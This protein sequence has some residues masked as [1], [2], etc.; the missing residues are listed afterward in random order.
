VVALVR[1]LISAYACDPFGGSEGANAWFTAEG[2]AQ[3]GA[4]VQILT[5]HTDAEKTEAGVQ[6]Y[7]ASPGRG[8]L[9]ATYLSDSVPSG[10][11]SGQLGVYA[12]YAA[13]QMRCHAWAK[14][15][16]NGPWDIGHHVSWGS[17][18]HPVGLAGCG[19]PLVIGP[20][21]GG[22]SLHPDHERWLDGDP[23]QDRRRAAALRRIIPLS[24][25]SR[26][27]AK[28]AAL[29][30]ATNEETVSLAKDLGA[31]RVELGLP[32]GLRPGQ[33]RASAPALPEVPEIVWIGRFLPLKAAGLAIS[34]FRRVVAEELDARLTMVGDGPTR[35]VIEASAADLVASGAVRFAGRLPW[36]EAQEVLA[37]A[38]V[39]LFT[40]VRDSSS[41]Q[42]LEAAALGVPTV[43]LDAY[44]S[45]A[46]LHRRGFAL[47]DPLPGDGLDERFATQILRILSL[48]E[49]AWH[50]EGSGALTFASEHLYRERAL[51]LLRKYKLAMA[52]KG[53]GT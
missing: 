48:D 10:L 49:V 4:D 6:D 17:L 40:S 47:V 18:S 44:G 1:V 41:A 14:D 34:A 27:A 15:D 25:V 26:Y 29:V 42:T 23:N 37:S 13:W 12:R 11:S 16:K 43:A 28:R 7:L 30:L 50:A 51:M 31:H 22:Q 24:P 19:F 33:L 45:S 39:H 35:E 21:G 38:R 8:R 2:L 9:N 32:E 3:A 20:V 52:A 53:Q 46:F 36:D 5:R